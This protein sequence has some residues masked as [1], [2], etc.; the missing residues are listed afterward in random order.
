MH[1]PKDDTSLWPSWIGE[2]VSCNVWVAG[3]GAAL[4][5]WTNAAMHVVDLGEALFAALQ[6]EP[7]LQGQSELARV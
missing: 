6:V 4:S 2:D 3:Y 7:G 5:G 1:D